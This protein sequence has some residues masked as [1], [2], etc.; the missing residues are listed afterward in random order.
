MAEQYHEVDENLIQKTV[1]YLDDNGESCEGFR[2]IL[3][4]GEAYREYGMTP[5]YL[6]DEGETYF[7]VIAAETRDKSKLH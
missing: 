4:I 6:T 5:V 1:Q 7:K 3:A 2:V